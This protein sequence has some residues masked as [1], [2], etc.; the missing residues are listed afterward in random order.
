MVGTKIGEK[1]HYSALTGTIK[2]RVCPL[3]F[4]LSCDIIVAVN[5]KKHGM[6]TG[7][8]GVHSM[9]FTLITAITAG[10]TLGNLV[11]PAVVAAAKIKMASEAAMAVG[12]CIGAG[13]GLAAGLEDVCREMY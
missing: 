12:T 1:Q 13:I 7:Q 2:M 6:D 10:A 4:Q 8:K 11:V 3:H 5:N 9:I